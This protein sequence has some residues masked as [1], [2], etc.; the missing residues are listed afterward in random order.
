MDDTTFALREAQRGAA[1]VVMA[2]LT[3]RQAQGA[4]PPDLQVLVDG[5][6]L[7]QDHLANPRLPDTP[8]GFLYLRPLTEP[9]PSEDAVVFEPLTEW[10]TGGIV[11]YAD[12]HVELVS[13]KDRYDQLL[14]GARRRA[15]VR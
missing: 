10:S 4:W 1:A 9:S 15:G 5:G 12:G 2:L 11:A 7:T 8:V 6:Y 3:Y 14:Q 13:D